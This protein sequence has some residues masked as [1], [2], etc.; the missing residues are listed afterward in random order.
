MATTHDPLREAVDRLLPE[1]RTPTEERPPTLDR[2]TSP[3]LGQTL[4]GGAWQI[5]TRRAHR[6]DW[7][8]P[9]DSRWWS[10]WEETIA[11]GTIAEIDSLTTHPHP[12]VRRLVATHP[13]IWGDI[14]EQMVNDE[15]PEVRAAVLRNPRLEPEFVDTLCRD[16]VDGVA[17]RGVDA[18]TIVGLAA[19]G[20]ERSGID[21]L[22]DT[23][24]SLG[25]EWTAP[26]SPSKRG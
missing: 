13:Q 6:G 12:G 18:A 26:P 11:V 4:L 7:L 20:R 24:T 8:H 14:R 16:E 9:L 23:A 1:E 10:G 2:P 25:I 19:A 5:A 17:V 21:T 3:A 22:S 15:W